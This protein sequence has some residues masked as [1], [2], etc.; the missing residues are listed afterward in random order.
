MDHLI[1]IVTIFYL[2]LDFFMLLG[3]PTWE[4]VSVFGDK[5][6]PVTAVML[7]AAKHLCSPRARPFASLRV[8]TR[9]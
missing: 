2:I 1:V 4:D 3:S 7:S 6:Y 5:T 9:E 8:T